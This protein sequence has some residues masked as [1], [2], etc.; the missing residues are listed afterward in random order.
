[1]F[2]WLTDSAILPHPLVS[3]VPCRY[4][5]LQVISRNGGFESVSSGLQFDS[6]C[7]GPSA[8]MRSHL[9]TGREAADWGATRQLADGR[10]LPR[11]AR[12]G[13]PCRHHCA[14]V[15]LR[16]SRYF[17]PPYKQPFARPGT[18][19]ETRSLT[20][21]TR[22]TFHAGEP[23]LPGGAAAPSAGPGSDGRGGHCCVRRPARAR[24]GLCVSHTSVPST[25]IC[26]IDAP[27]WESGTIARVCTH[28]DA[29]PRL[30]G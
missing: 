17:K 29:V 20:T 13:V 30:V 10:R 27:V 1:M 14:A 9:G 16:P 6:A 12:S 3:R 24:R 18:H 15:T 26:V 23:Q 19:Y 7:D 22:M 28:R 5:L 21:A 11:Q 8:Q 2:G 4:M 25:S